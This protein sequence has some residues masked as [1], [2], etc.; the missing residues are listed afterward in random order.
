VIE[1]IADSPRLFI[2]SD[3]DGT[4]AEIVDDPDLASPL[5]RSKTALEELA[6]LDH[7][8]V[9]VISGRR[10]ADLLRRFDHPGF[11]LIGEHGAD[12]GNTTGPETPALAQARALVDAA[13]SA[14]PGARVEH[15]TR[16][17]GFHYRSVTD[18]DETVEGLRVEARKIKG[19]RLLEAKKIL[20]LTDSSVDKGA[21]FVELRRSLGADRALFIGDDVTDESVFAALQQGDLGVH[22]GEGPTLANLTVPDPSGVADLLETLLRA[23]STG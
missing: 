17:V 18:P 23:R 2:A 8:T 3:F 7:T 20:E 12:H 4:L 6:N 15:K 1:E 21:A 9:A 22:V 13:V 11:V 16:A 5:A 10:R 19:L 14:T